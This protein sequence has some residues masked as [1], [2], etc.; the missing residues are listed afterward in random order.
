MGWGRSCHDAHT[1]LSPA[2]VK[3]GSR[4][5]VL[6]RVEYDTRVSDMPLSLILPLVIVPMVIVIVVSVYCY[7]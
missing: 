5:W 4:E 6:G 1:E 3:F 2:Q 7:W